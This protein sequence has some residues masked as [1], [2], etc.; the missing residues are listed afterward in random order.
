MQRLRL[1]VTLFVVSALCAAR[2]AERPNI[3]FIAVDDLR[4]EFGAYG[5]NYIKSPNLDRLAEG[6]HHVQPRLLPAGGLFADA[7]EPADRH[8]ARHHEGLGS[9]THFR[10]ALPDVVT[11]GQH[12]KNNGYFVQGMGKIYPR[13]LRRPADPGPCRGK[14]PTARPT[15]CPKTS[16]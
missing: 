11:L 13:R 10:T 3:L 5:A 15:A 1:L 7:L 9:V 4:P 16:L 6:G 2:A 14:R 8:A 12:F